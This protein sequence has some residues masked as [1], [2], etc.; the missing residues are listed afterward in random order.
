MTN[1]PP[2]LLEHVQVLLPGN[3]SHSIYRTSYTLMSSCYLS[4]AIVVCSRPSMFF[5]LWYTRRYKVA[6]VES[7]VRYGIILCIFEMIAGNDRSVVAKAPET[8]QPRKSKPVITLA[9]SAVDSSL[10]AWF[11]W[12]MVQ[13]RRIAVATESSLWGVNMILLYG[14]PAFL[15]Q[16]PESKIT[17]KNNPSPITRSWRAPISTPWVITR[18]S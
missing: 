5:Y 11:I 15:S 3:P 7:T 13:K 14:F 6:A 12:R 16:M 10:V 8:M 1:G 9:I 4:E 2:T 17:R 18:V